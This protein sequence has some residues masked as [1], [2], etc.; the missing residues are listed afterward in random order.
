MLKREPIDCNP[1]IWLNPDKTNFYD[2]TQDDIKVEGYP[3]VLI[4][5]NNPQ[6]KIDLGI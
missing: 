1:T 5:E 3:R 4:K 2:F 6:M